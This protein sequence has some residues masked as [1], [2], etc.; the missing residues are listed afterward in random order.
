MAR[1]DERDDARR[2]GASVS[3]APQPTY[4]RTGARS[5]ELEK[6]LNSWGMPHNAEFVPVQ[7]YNAEKMIDE[8]LASTWE[9]PR[10]RKGSQFAKVD[11]ASGS[12]GALAK[13][14]SFSKQ[15]ASMNELNTVLVESIERLVKH[16]QGIAERIATLE[17]DNQ[18]VTSKYQEGLKSPELLLN[19]ICEEMEDLEE[20]FTKVSSTAVSIGDRL[21][22]LDRERSRVLET[23]E[24]MEALLALNDPASKTIKSSNRL[25]N[26]LRD[27]SQLHEASRAIK[28]M[29]VFSTELS[30]PAISLAVTEIEHLSQ[31]IET[32]LLNE[33]SEAQ[34]RSDEKTMKKCAVSLIEYNDKEKVAD[35]YVWNVFKDK[36]AKSMESRSGSV[37]SLDPIQDLEAL[38]TKIHAICK[39]QFAII[40]HVFPKAACNSTRELLVERLFNDPAFGI[41]SC[42][43]QFLTVRH[44][45]ISSTEA[46]A[47][48]GP[49]PEYVRLLCAAYEKTCDLTTTLEALDFGKQPSKT[50]SVP[51]STTPPAPASNNDLN[52]E[53]EENDRER[54]R[55]FLNLQLHSLFGSHRQRYYRT[56]L[57][58]A[59]HRF[60]TIFTDVRF[61]QQLT[62]KQKVAATK[63]KAA[64]AK[65][66]DASLATP[67]T[68]SSASSV[69]SSNFEKDGILNPAETALSYFETLSQ[70]VQDDA[71]TDKYSQ[72]LKESVSRCDIILKDC[73][74]RG[75][76]IT[77]LFSSYCAGFADEFLVKIA[78]MSNELLQQPLLTSDSARQYF[79][80]LEHVL[81]RIELFEEQFDTVI[82]PLQTDSPT[83]QTIGYEIKRKSLDKL[84]NAIAAGLQQVFTVVEKHLS[85]I[86]AT[87]QEKADFIGSE[88]NMSLSCS[89]ACKRCVDYMQPL[90]KIIS[91]VLLEENRD[92]F[93]IGLCT[94]FKEL[95]LQ[96]LQKY[97]FDPDGACM[98]L[99]DVNA[100]RQIF[101]SY[102][103]VA[104]DDIFDIL[105]EVANIFALPPENLGGFVRDGKLATMNKQSLMD[106]IKRRWDY[107]TQ[108]DK[109]LL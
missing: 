10:P 99:R 54:M 42:L 50:N 26:T 96:H 7:P 67:A 87:T 48:D 66:G 44:M 14:A 30:S 98:L 4:G 45:S 11:E 15:T 36:L 60:K 24:L 37:S 102:R 43:E 73:E 56:E 100:Y 82:T 68:P 12:P 71:I 55:T 106:I 89:R 83:Q 52:G 31:S 22:T 16:R 81:E 72:V 62:A 32:D 8:L 3:A 9:A 28:K 64:A 57:E 18:K 6:L 95:Y 58:L 27:K 1:E 93:L 35:R 59:Q 105:H 86:L 85:N 39:E 108:G 92:R 77:K 107:K 109:I 49:N 70:I 17:K 97:R 79:G 88:A 46:S 74:M 76:L 33:F 47:P 38:F 34:E 75:E 101:R 78:A 90:V 53:D 29:L 20:R 2:R 104:I 61:P 25:F 13:A 94:I 23:D 91:E 69:T 51:S 40:D 84:E 41:M 65:A 19:K 63:S 80:I 21:S 103:H 5:E